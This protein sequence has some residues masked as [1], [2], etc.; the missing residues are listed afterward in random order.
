MTMKKGFTLIELLVVISVISL[1]ASI[2]FVRLTSAR[3]KAKVALVQQQVRQIALAIQLLYEDIGKWPAHR[4]GMGTCY[5]HI[6]DPADHTDWRYEPWEEFGC[7]LQTGG[8][9]PLDDPTRYLDLTLPWYGLTG[10][11]ER[12]RDEYPG[13]NGPYLSA[14]IANSLRA[15]PWGE[16]G[17][18]FDGDLSYDPDGDG[19][20]ERYAGV[21][22]YGPDRHYYPTDPAVDEIVILMCKLWDEE[23]GYDDVQ[24]PGAW[25]PFTGPEI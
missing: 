12:N 4:N 2:G 18:I 24:C 1:I 17:Y 20:S 19:W 10:L 5:D 14:E 22:S 21:M 8:G 6:E 11:D 3:D 16:W 13:W 15:D 7:E 25:I 23:S 9:R